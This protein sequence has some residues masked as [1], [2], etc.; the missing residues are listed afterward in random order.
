[1]NSDAL[2][3]IRLRDVTAR[4]FAE[5]NSRGLT[6]AETD[7]RDLLRELDRVTADLAAQVHLAAQRINASSRA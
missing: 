7:R 4:A 5:A 3:A 1:M 2:L 6:C